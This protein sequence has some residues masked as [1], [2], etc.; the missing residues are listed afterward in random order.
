MDSSYQQLKQMV[1]EHLPLAKDAIHIYI[2]IA[3]LALS[4]LLLRQPLASLRALALGLA[5]SVAMEVMD[6][7]DNRNYPQLV[8][9]LGS[10]RDVA[11]TNLVPLIVVLLAKRRR[12][13]P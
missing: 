4:V 2:G 11:N 12:K 5:V 8:R 7:R 1:L 9:W 3:C 10:L 13:E 6:L